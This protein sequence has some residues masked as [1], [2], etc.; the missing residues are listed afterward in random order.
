MTSYARAAY[1]PLDVAKPVADG[2]WIVDS[3]P[4]RVMGIPL[5]LRMTVIRL[6]NGELLLHSPTRYSEALHRALDGLGRIRHL[7][8]PDIAHWMFLKG[9]QEACPDTITWAAP[10]LRER[11]PPRKAGVRFDRDLEEQAPDAWAGEITQNVIHGGFGYS[12]VAFFHHATRTLVLTD[13]VVNLEPAKTP[14][15]MRPA[16]HLAGM[17]APRGMAPVYVRWIIALRR[18][19]AASVAARLLAHHPERV[20]FAHGCWFERNGEAALRHALRWLL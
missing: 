13:L 15:L 5:P 11:A 3:A 20:I 7:V 16:L 12:E 14:L 2:V 18:R 4:I 19:E 10:G 8:A 9:W 1:K 6:R 17:L